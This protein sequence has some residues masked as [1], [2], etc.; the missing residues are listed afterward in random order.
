ML[1]IDWL[2][3]FSLT[4]SS[5]MGFLHEHK[6]QHS[7]LLQNQK[8]I[9]TKFSTKFKNLG[10]YL[11]RLGDVRFLEKENKWK[12][13]DAHSQLTCWRRIH[14]WFGSYAT[15]MLNLC[16]GFPILGLHVSCLII[17]PRIGILKLLLEINTVIWLSF[18]MH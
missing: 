1:E 18:S 12:I 8:I 16:Q 11:T 15:R 13:V 14:A 7:L 10:K 2:R 4:F 3:A 9:L 17:L 6:K 5:N